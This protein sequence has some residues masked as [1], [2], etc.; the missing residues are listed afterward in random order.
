MLGEDSQKMYGFKVGE[1]V[2]TKVELFD[3]TVSL[4]IDSG[5]K[6]RLVCFV[7]KVK[8]SQPHLQDSVFVD[9]KEYFYNAVRANQK[10]DHGRRIRANF[11]TIKKIKKKA[12]KK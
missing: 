9:G 11:C 10:S 6:L 2:E 12:V 7:P 4:R 1:I 8:L 3:E 5:T